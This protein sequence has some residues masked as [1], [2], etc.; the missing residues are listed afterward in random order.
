M[1]KREKSATTEPGNGVA[2]L[3]TGLDVVSV[4]GDLTKQPHEGHMD[5][6]AVNSKNS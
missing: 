4:S 5:D 1:S 2:M 3:E 6:P